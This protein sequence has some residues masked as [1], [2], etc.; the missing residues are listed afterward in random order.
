MLAPPPGSVSNGQA[1]TL[2]EQ[3]KGVKE[4]TKTLQAR[5]QH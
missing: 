4:K 1:A 3:S 2:V 5:T